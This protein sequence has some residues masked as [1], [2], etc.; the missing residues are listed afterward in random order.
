MICVFSDTLRCVITTLTVVSGDDYNYDVVI[1][2]I[3]ALH[4]IRVIYSVRKT[5]IKYLEPGD[6]T[7]HN[8]IQ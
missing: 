6:Q 1:R 8:N 7:V 5:S 4:F 2:L 3:R